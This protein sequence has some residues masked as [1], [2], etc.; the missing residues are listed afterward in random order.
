MKFVLYIREECPFCILAVE[1]I[2]KRNFD[3]SIVNAGRCEETLSELKNAYNWNT[4]PMI[5]LQQEQAYQMIGGYDS[6]KTFLLE[7]KDG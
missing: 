6:L 7:Q 3:F 4:V 2:M 1:E 5:F